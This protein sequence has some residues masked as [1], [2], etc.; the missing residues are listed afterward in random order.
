MRTAL[1]GLTAACHGNVP[2]AGCPILDA[3]NDPADGAPPTPA[4][5]E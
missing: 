3:L 5:E 2:V 1:K 4:A